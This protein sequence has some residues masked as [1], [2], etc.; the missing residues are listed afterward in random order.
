MIA[1]FDRC[2]RAVQSRDP[3]FDGWFVT[4]VTSTGIYCRPSCPA[5]TPKR[6]Y[7]RFHASAA[8]AQRAGFRA[9]RRCRPEAA[10][11]SPEWDQRGDVVARAMRL[12]ADG[13]IDR[14]GVQGLAAELG[15]SAAEIQRR[16]VAEVGAG[17]AALARAQRAQTAR[18]LIDATSL[19]MAEIAFT[20]GFQ[21]VRQ[22]N[23]TVRAVFGLPPRRLRSPRA[24]PTAG[25]P[26]RLGLKLSFRRP[27]NPGNLFGH[28]AATAVPGVEEVR[29]GAYRRS[30]RLPRGPGT[31][32][33]TPRADHVA[34]RLALADLGDLTPAIARCRWLLDLDADPDEV[35]E[36][37]TGDPA[38]RPLVN[39]APGRR[40]PRTV[41]GAELAMRAV[42]GQQISTAAA[43]TQ[44]A[45]LTVAFGEPLTDP[46]GS[47][48]H[49]FP[50]PE[51]LTEARLA[52]PASRGRTL[53][54]LVSALASG[55][56]SVHPAGD[57]TQTRD[58][59]RQLPG[60]GPWTEEIVAMRALGDPDAFPA[61]D[62]GVRRAAEAL[63]LPAGP[64]G[65]IA[66]AHGWR[67][68]RAYAVQYLWSVLP[69][70]INEWPPSGPAG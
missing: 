41:D 17:P 20:A 32:A 34:C 14:A 52:G 29:D 3:R 43:R 9:C 6:E 46:Q 67:P 48:T 15:H 51:S 69:H 16:L 63:G 47:I 62:L 36:Q 26:G 21:G 61:T 56:L 8:A 70:A 45:R 1:D 37:L 53:H 57:R 55:R 64:T 19:P 59:L 42:L 4:A 49:L 38:L 40:V 10:P 44:A 18:T 2:Y 25:A 11:G 24:Q 33:L 35:D 5:R 31:V 27:L 39:Q 54:A 30:L 50:V 65:L 66:A 58:G 23:D 68:W 12:I 7:V 60:I 13:I 22:F 28:L